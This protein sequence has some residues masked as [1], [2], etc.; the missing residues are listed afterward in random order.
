VVGKRKQTTILRP[1]RREFGGVPVCMILYVL[2]GNR[3]E[4]NSR[5]L[6][7]THAGHGVLLLAVPALGGLKYN[8]NAIM[9]MLMF[10]KAGTYSAHTNYMGL[11]ACNREREQES[12]DKL[13]EGF[14]LIDPPISRIP[15][16]LVASDTGVA[17][18]SAYFQSPW[19][20]S[21]PK[22]P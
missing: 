6:P 19:R 20:H 10:T 8:V 7:R 22:S 17:F 15:R 11:Q 18:T 16:S 3:K 12:M 9:L 2:Q 5:N 21:T 1:A 13:Q 14:P 4:G